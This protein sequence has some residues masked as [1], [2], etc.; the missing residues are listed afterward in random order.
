M[1]DGRM[2]GIDVSKGDDAE[3]RCAVCCERGGKSEWDGFRSR[4]DTEDGGC[5][6]FVVVLRLRVD[7]FGV[8]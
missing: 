1:G 3:V 6:F 8:P 4:V 5:P 7:F 2:N